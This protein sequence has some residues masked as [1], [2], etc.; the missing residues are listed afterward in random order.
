MPIKWTEDSVGAEYSINTKFT[1]SVD[2]CPDCCVGGPLLSA[3]YVYNKTIQMT[4]HKGIKILYCKD[5]PHTIDL[6]TYP[7]DET[8][9]T[10]YILIEKLSTA[11]SS[12]AVA[13][14]GSA[15]SSSSMATNGTQSAASPGTSSTSVPSSAS[16]MNVSLLFPMFMILA[17]LFLFKRT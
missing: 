15:S 1:D 11:N 4:C 13:G 10:R 16:Q 8:N 17:Y 5:S 7:C 6:L 14:S 2:H 12:A 9:Y 3:T